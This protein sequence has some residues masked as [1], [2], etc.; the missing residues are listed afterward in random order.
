MKLL[1]FEQI[2]LILSQLDLMPFIEAGFV[3]YSGKQAV[4][5]PVRQ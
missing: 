2:E 5:P 4:V 1:E 3:A